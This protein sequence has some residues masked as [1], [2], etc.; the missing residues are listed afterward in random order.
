[1]KIAHIV[2]TFPPYNGGMGN[3]VFSLA[4]E[5]IN[6][7]EEVTVFT[8]DYFES[9][10]MKDTGAEPEKIH[11]ESIN[12]NLD[13]VNRL[14][15]ALQYGNAAYL[16]QIAEEL[17][18]FDIVHLH[19]PFFGVANLVRKWKLRNPH[20]KLVVTYHMDTRGPGWKGLFFKYYGYFWLPKILESADCLLATSLDYL[21]VSLASVH[22]QKHPEKWQELPLGVDSQ[23]F[24]PHEKNDILVQSL[25]LDNNFPTILFVGGMDEAHYFKGVPVLLKALYLLKQN[26]FVCQVVLVGEGNLKAEFKL[27]TKSLGLENQI[28]FADNV[29]NENLPYFYN[30]ADLFVLPSTTAG[31]AYGLVLLEAMSS[32]VPVIASDLP[33]VRKVAELGGK[34]VPASNAE[35]LAQSIQAYFSLSNNE[36]ENLKKEVRQI[37]EVDY[38]WSIITQKLRQIYQQ[39][40]VKT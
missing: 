33:G 14:R 7:G 18:Q 3:V 30:L 9:S 26:N 10:E 22:Y 20:K 1:M 21:K 16:P 32:G 25:G 6:Q 2:C 24:Q 5:L 29:D 28:I 11:T 37:V 12:N 35:L 39:L 4:S 23:K 17:N 13:F 38:S 15:P 27:L 34:V 40:V 36:K 19:Y 31:E 8:P